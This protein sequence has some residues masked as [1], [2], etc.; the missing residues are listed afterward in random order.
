MSVT[1]DK[2]RAVVEG[3]PTG[4]YIGGEWRDASGGETFGVEDPA[5]GETLADVA[6]GTPDDARAAL[7]GPSVV[8]VPIDYSQDIALQDQLGKETVAA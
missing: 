1:A 6:D 5:T 4:L 3:V 8:V 7:D 2:D